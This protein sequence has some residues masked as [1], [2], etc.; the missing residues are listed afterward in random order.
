VERLKK[1]ENILADLNALGDW[2]RLETCEDAQP[3]KEPSPNRPLWQRV[4]RKF[5]WNEHL[6]QSLIELQVRRPNGLVY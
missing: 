2:A 4:D 5:W 3:F 6:Q 1:Q